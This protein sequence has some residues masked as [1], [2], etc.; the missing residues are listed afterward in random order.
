MLILLFIMWQLLYLKNLLTLYSLVTTS[1]M[2]LPVLLSQRQRIEFDAISLSYTMHSVSMALTVFPAWIK[3]LKYLTVFNTM[4]ELQ[5]TMSKVGFS[6][7]CFHLPRGIVTIDSLS[8]YYS[9]NISHHFSPLLS[10]VT[11]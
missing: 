6:L 4:C 11:A 10:A 5:M 1:I 9:C 7:L 2:V 3:A 8:S